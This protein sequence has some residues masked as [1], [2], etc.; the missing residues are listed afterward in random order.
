M[1]SL[2]LFFYFWII[3]VMRRLASPDWT[4]NSLGC[5]EAVWNGNH[6]CKSRMVLQGCASVGE[7]GSG[8]GDNWT[9]LKEPPDKTAL[10]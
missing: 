6:D 3:S 10:E 2:F 5:E 1:F 4:S 8:W 7:S 9:R